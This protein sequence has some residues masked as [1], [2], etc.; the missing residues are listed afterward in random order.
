MKGG[1]IGG[2]RS[3]VVFCVAAGWLGDGDVEGHGFTSVK[4]KPHSAIEDFTLR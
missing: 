3:L 1:K 2:Q 4:T